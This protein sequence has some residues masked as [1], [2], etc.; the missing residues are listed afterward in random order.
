VLAYPEL[1]GTTEF[2]IGL[3]STANWSTANIKQN[4]A[5]QKVNKKQHK[6]S[7]IQSY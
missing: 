6:D 4:P 1:K 7:E 3:R 5:P 2:R